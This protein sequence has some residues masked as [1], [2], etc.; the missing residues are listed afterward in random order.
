VSGGSGGG[1][2][3]AGGYGGGGAGTNGLGGGGGAG[4]RNGGNGGTG[5][6]ILRV[7]RAALST[8]GSPASTTVG[9]DYVYTF[10]ANG[11]ITF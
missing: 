11:S 7:P 3:G 5:V 10:T 4:Y 6:V 1:G 8:T 9:S 2:T